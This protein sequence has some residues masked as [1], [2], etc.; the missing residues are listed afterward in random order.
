MHLKLSKA[1]VGRIRI[2]NMVMRTKSMSRAAHALTIS[3]SS[4]YLAIKKL[5]LLYNDVLFVRDKNLL[6]PTEFAKVLHTE[7]VGILKAQSG[8]QSLFVDTDRKRFIFA[9]APHI[10]ATVIPLTYLLMQDATPFPLEHTALPASAENKADLLLSNQVDVIFDYI[11]IEHDD[12][13][14]KR[15]FKEDYVIVCRKDHPRLSDSIS[16]KEFSQEKHAVLGCSYKFDNLVDEKNRDN[17]LF[18]S[19]YYL[20][21]LAMVEVCELI[22]IIPMNIYLKLHA[23][24]N[25]KSLKYNFKLNVKESNLYINYLKDPTRRKDKDMLLKK[26]EKMR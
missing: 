19:H 2:F 1:E 8:S 3:H 23:S 18:C 20:D 24:F 4:V 10:A 14:Y 11:P 12:I 17:I 26:I 6:V 5:R 16:Q 9:C 21:L 15:L 25:I 7:T 22:C 13:Y